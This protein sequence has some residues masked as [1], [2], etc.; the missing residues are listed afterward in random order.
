MRI[1][2]CATRRTRRLS[3]HQRLTPSLLVCAARQYHP[4]VNSGCAQAATQF[5]RVKEA[6]DSVLRDALL[7]EQSSQERGSAAYDGAQHPGGRYERHV[8]GRGRRSFDPLEQQRSAVT[9]ADFDLDYLTS[10]QAA[11]RRAQHQDDPYPCA[12]RLQPTPAPA[13]NPNP[14]SNPN[15][16]PNPNPNQAALRRAQHQDDRCGSYADQRSGNSGYGASGS[17]G[18]G[19][20]AEEAGQ[21]S[22]QQEAARERAMPRGP[23]PAGGA[24]WHVDDVGFGGFRDRWRQWCGGS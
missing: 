5:V 6:Y 16:N 22:G 7:F 12:L 17:A 21:P 23:M 18:H 19:R 1:R 11:L 2:D 4:D 24:E 14:N 9:M 10:V 8:S 15:P 3:P 20:A 13:L